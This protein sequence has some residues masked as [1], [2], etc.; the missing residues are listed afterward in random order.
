MDFDDPDIFEDDMEIME[1]I[2]FGFPRRIYTRSNLFDTLDDF[3]FFK[4]FRLYKETVLFILTF[5]EGDLE[6][7]N[8]M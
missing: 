2:D 8:N 3:T 1:I 7:P 4:R 5:I 6:Y